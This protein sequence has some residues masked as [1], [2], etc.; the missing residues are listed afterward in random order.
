MQSL[1]ILVPTYGRTHLLAECVESFMRQRTDV[2]MEMIVL[3]DHQEQQLVMAEQS[4][5]T[6]L[7]V[8]A[9]TRFADLGTKRNA[10]LGMAAYDW[11][12]YW[13]D[14]DVYLP[15][16]VDRMAALIERL[17]DV[18][19]IKPGMRFRAARDS[20]CWQLDGQALALRDS[21]PMWSMAVERSALRE[22]GGFAPMDR[23][24]DVDMFRRVIAKGWLRAEGNTP[25]MPACMH[26]TSA[27]PRAT[28]VASAADYAAAIGVLMDK[29]LEPRGDVVIAPIWSDDYEAMAEAA[30][31][32]PPGR[33]APRHGEPISW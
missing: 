20:H 13:D 30:W 3:N 26:R 4:E 8:N 33:V 14:D 10:L 12:W 7:V 16:A 19:R 32:L 23:M 6:V 24:Q 1:S 11:V 9:L 17:P 29:G 31:S 22:L 15:T 25:G 2:R 5:R 27:Q 21:G 18:S 28:G